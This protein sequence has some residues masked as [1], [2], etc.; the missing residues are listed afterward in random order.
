MQL[1]KS[2]HS[3]GAAGEKPYHPTHK[4]EFLDEQALNCSSLRDHVFGGGEVLVNAL[5]WEQEKE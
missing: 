3:V 2:S 1:T 5:T 4:F